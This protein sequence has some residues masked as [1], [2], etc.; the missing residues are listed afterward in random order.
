ML[1]SHRHRF[2]FLKTFK[3]AGTSLESYF[4]RHC[5]PAGA[6]QPQP[7]RRETVTSQGIIGHRGAGLGPEV[8]WW[9]HMT[10]SAVCA[11]LGEPQWSEY[12]KFCVVRNPYDK[13]VSMFFFRRQ[14]GI[15]KPPGAS[16]AEQL[17]NALRLEAPVS[18]RNVYCIDDRI[19]VDS[20][21]RYERLQADL[22]DLCTRLGLP[23]RPQELPRYKAGFRPPEARVEAL[24]TE[25]S[26]AIV[27]HAYAWEFETFGYGFGD[28]AQEIAP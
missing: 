9:N 26:R 4:E 23:W 21:L 12:H 19:A 6:W 20:V 3:T 10:A 14:R 22:A 16:E 24:Y 8:R 2:I 27:R 13:V 15:I 1:I 17:E 28:Q 18:D 25:A 7:S 5:L 11:Q